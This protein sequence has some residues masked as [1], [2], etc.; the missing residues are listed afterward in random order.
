MSPHPDPSRAPTRRRL[1]WPLITACCVA[2]TATAVL[3]CGG[4][5][6]DSILDSTREE[7]LA[8][9][10]ASFANEIS[11]LSLPKT[12]F[13]HVERIKVDEWTR[14]RHADHSLDA[15]LRDISAAMGLGEKNHDWHDV[16]DN[17]KQVRSTVLEFHQALEQKRPG[18]RLEHAPIKLPEIEISRRLPAEFSLYLHGW[19]EYQ[20]NRPENARKHLQGL[21]ELPAEQRT[22]RSVWAA[23]LIAR[24]YQ[25]SDP[26]KA[27]EWFIKTRDLAKAGNK[28][29]LGLAAASFGW[30][31]RAC[32][33]LGEFDNAINLYLLQLSAG[34]SSAVQSL[35]VTA[36]AALAAGRDTLARLASDASHRAVLTAYVVANGGPWQPAPGSDR[37]AAWLD[38]CEAAGAHDVAGAD[39]LAW[40]AYQH[41]RYDLAHRWAGETGPSH[42]AVGPGET[43]AARRQDRAGH[44][45]A[46]QC[47][48]RRKRVQRSRR[49]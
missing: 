12:R 20:F 4:Y 42:R 11:R 38:A 49:R 47:G 45:A 39:R 15:D 31:A 35:Q 2:L 18:G 27:V 32:L 33:D 13:R 16:L 7:F 37:V 29:S 30:Q 19:K 3:A 34:D 25:P 5:D 44:D 48:A 43:A 23:Y 40:T 24:S 21:L 9:P 46:G 14:Q 28:D 17:V 22:Y 36:T 10:S 41:G 6:D 1:Q 26:R 8:M